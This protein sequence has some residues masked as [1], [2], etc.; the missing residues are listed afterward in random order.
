MKVVNFLGDANAVENTIKQVKELLNNGEV[1]NARVLLN[2][3]QSEIDISVINLP[4][5]TYP[6]ALKLAS[7]Y[8]LEEKPQKAK[9]VLKLALSTFTQIN[10]II[11]IP[12]INAVNLIFSASDISKKDKQEAIKYLEGASDELDKAEKL[13]YISKSTTTYKELHS[14]IKDIQKEING[15][16]KAEELFK[17]LSEKLEKFKEK[18]FSSEKS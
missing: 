14:M 8:I 18:I 6:A 16:N 4:L 11:P 7:K 15:E 9:E 17:S 12:V 1:Q 3:L 5:V 13:G 10:E 2:T